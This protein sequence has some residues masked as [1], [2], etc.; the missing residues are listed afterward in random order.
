MR[1][2]FGLGPD[3]S[4]AD[5]LDVFLGHLDETGTEVDL[6][7]VVFGDEPDS[8]AADAHERLAEAGLAAEV[9]E[10]EGDPGSRMVEV[11]ERE[12]FDRIVLPGGQRSPLGKIQ[13]GRVAEFVVLNATTTIT[14]IR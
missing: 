12:E 11:A 9:R 14:L 2:L 7:V 6:T 1:A 10:I 5:A 4:A 8:L 13:L 3:R